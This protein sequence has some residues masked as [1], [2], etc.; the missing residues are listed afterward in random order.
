MSIKRSR[1]DFGELEMCPLHRCVHFERTHLTCTLQM[2]VISECMLYLIKKLGHK[3]VTI[4]KARREAEG[5]RGPA[6]GWI[7]WSLEQEPDP[8]LPVASLG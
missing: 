6:S 2:C 3:Q 1:L 8:G 7:W 4:T 5:P